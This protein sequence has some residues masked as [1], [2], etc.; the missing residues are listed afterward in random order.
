M[1]KTAYAPAYP[2]DSFIEIFPDIYL[3]QGSIKIALGLSMNR[4]MV[5]VK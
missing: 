1:I 5:I 4:N 2:H 3:L